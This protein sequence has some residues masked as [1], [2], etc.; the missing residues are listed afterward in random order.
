VSPAYPINYLSI[1]KKE[2][3]GIMANYVNL[4]YF[5]EEIGISR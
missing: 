5:D 1:H 3:D 4:N 2:F